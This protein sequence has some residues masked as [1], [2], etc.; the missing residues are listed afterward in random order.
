MTSQV[1]LLHT[2]CVGNKDNWTAGRPHK[3]QVLLTSICI[4]NKQVLPFSIIAIFPFSNAWHLPHIYQQLLTVSRQTVDE[5]LGQLGYFYFP[6]CL[7]SPFRGSAWK[8]WAV[9]YDFSSLH[10]KVHSLPIYNALNLA[11][12]KLFWH[13]LWFTPIASLIYININMLD[14]IHITSFYMYMILPDFLAFLCL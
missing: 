12:M 9:L 5:A 14:N 13:I 6:I 10:L 3:E 11:F 4:T 2:F 1:L 8:K 7:H